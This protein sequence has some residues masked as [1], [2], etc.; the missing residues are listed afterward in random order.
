M[1]LLI[2]R[3]CLFFSSHVE[4]SKVDPNESWQTLFSEIQRQAGEC[5]GFRVEKGEGF[6]HALKEE[7]HGEAEGG[8][9]QR[10]TY[11]VTAQV[12]VGL[13]PVVGFVGCGELQGLGLG[14]LWL[15]LSC[16][17]ER[18]VKTFLIKS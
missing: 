8:Q 11:F 4:I 15:V 10:R 2:S 3:F 16:K 1:F 12:A 18:K 7:C 17:S 6:S 9:T 14:F 13:L 5:E